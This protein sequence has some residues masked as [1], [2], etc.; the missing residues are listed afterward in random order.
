VKRTRSSSRWKIAVHHRMN[1]LKGL[2]T[3]PEKKLYS[4]GILS[5]R[6]LC[7]PDFLVI[8]AQKAGTTWLKKNLDYHPE[9]FM[10]TRTGK[11]DPTE[12]RYFDQEFHEPLSFYSDLFKPGMRRVKGDK[13][14]NYCTI[15]LERIKF[16]RSI[17]PDVR[18]ILMIRNPIERAWSHAA[19]NLMK[20]S[21]KKM[22]EISNSKFRRHFI[23]SRGRGDYP[24]ILD[25]WLKIFPSEQL[26]V[27]FFE[28]I[29]LCPKKLLSEVFAHLGVSQDVDWKSFPY[30]RVINK[31]PKV[32]IPEQHRNFLELMYGPA[33]EDLYQRFGSKVENWRC[34]NSRVE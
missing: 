10:P 15:P 18:L 34:L 20:F 16:I 33:I 29:S 8:G 28:D 7:L 27:G 11:S 2:L 14:P 19:M 21:G 26:Y 13:S 5:T 9:I 23:R 3:A 22:E 6:S 17:M 1:S 4:L 25:R 32:P 30:Q 31:G 12:V 24:A